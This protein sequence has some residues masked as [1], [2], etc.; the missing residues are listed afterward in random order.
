MGLHKEGGGGA[1]GE[2][3]L[4]GWYEKGGQGGQGEGRDWRAG[5]RK[6]ERGNT[7]RESSGAASSSTLPGHSY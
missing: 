6:G 1:R 2:Q 3:G 4:M 5:M 7:S